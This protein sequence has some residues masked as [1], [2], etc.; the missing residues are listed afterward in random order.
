ME[1]EKTRVQIEET[2]RSEWVRACRVGGGDVV[3]ESKRGS[4][5]RRKCTHHDREHLIELRCLHDGVHRAVA[6]RGDRLTRGSSC[7]NRRLKQNKTNKKVIALGR[8]KKSHG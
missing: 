8:R 2:V 3:W 6:R 1:M 5:R 7:H 4:T